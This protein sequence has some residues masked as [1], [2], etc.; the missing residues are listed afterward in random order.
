M[1]P[2]LREEG[3]AR[4]A[5]VAARI[6]PADHGRRMTLHEFREAEEEFGYRYELA[7]GILEV[8]EVPNDPHGFIVCNFGRAV[9]DYDRRRPGFI[10]RFGEASSFRLWLPG[11]VSGRNP[12]FSVVIQ[13]TSKDRRGRR[14]PSLVVEVVSEGDEARDRDYREKREDYLRFGVREYWILDPEL[15]RVTVLTRDGDVWDEQVFDDGQVAS[16]LVLPGF[17]VPVADLWAMPPD[18]EEPPA[19]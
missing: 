2:T 9:G 1:T 19:R 11:M 3:T 14:P 7:R 17:A 13:G 8:T 10:L 12:D 15:R 4:M 6:G 18:D 16:G 5:T